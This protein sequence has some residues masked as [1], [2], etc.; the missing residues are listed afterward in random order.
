MPY[1]RKKYHRGDTHLKKGW[2]TKRKTKDLDE[3]DEDLKEENVRQLL[4]QEVDFD[5]PG[6]AQY[7]CPHCA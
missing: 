4:N 1:K 7:Y 5:K 2:R 3:I 6:A